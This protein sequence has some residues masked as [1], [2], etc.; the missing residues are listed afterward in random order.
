MLAKWLATGPK[1]LI[2]DEPTRGIDVGTKAEVHRLLSELAAEG[3]AVLMISSELPEVLGMA[4]RVL[5]MHEG[6][7]AAELP[8][9]EADR[10]DG[11]AARRPGRRRRHER[12]A[13]PGR[14]GRRR[15]RTRSATRRWIDT[16]VRARELSLIGVLAVLRG[17]ASP[18]SPTRASCPRRASSDLLLNATILALLAVGQSLV[19]ITR[20]IDLSV[21]SV[22]GLS[23]LRDRRPV[24]RP[25]RADPAWCSSLGIAARRGLRADQRR[26]WSRSA[27]VPALV[28]TLGTLYV[29]RGIDYCVGARPADQRRRP[30]ATASCDLGTRQRRSASRSCALIALVAMLR[31]RRRACAATASGRELYAIGSNPDAAGSPASRS[32]RRVLGAFVA[33]GA[34]AGLAGVLYAARFGTRRRRRR[35]RLRAARGRRAVVVGGVAIF[36]G[37]RHASTARRSARCC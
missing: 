31:R 20:N 33:C 7:I 35:H 11:H 18:R 6:R 26:C 16:V 30:A 15:R 14:P 1:V 2:V 29:F 36:G 3:V 34:L 23:R 24:R 17:R 12:A 8:R 22:L 27:R 5:V 37:V 19:V 32:R 9:A 10:G 4:D 25:R 21:G 28:V 13:R